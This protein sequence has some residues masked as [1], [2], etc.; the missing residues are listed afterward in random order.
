MEFILGHKK[1]VVLSIVPFILSVFNCYIYLKDTSIITGLVPLSWRIIIT[2]LVLYVSVIWPVLKDY[3][4]LIDK[5]KNIFIRG[6]LALV[7]CYAITI[8]VHLAMILISL[9]VM[10]AGAA[11]YVLIKVIKYIFGL[12]A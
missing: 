12:F 1:L 8:M 3:D 9:A 6:I 2:A 7:Y 10:L 11:I 5:N 4:D